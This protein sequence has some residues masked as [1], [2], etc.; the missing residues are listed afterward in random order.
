MI[1]RPN[2]LLFAIGELPLDRLRAIVV[3]IDKLPLKR[4][5]PGGVLA[6][7]LRQVARSLDSYGSDRLLRSDGASSRRL[8]LGFGFGSRL[9]LGSRILGRLAER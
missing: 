6:V 2:A 8:I 3:V 5:A 9:G 7:F 4:R 1:K